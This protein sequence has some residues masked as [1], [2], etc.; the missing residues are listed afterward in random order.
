MSRIKKNKQTIVNIRRASCRKSLE[1]AALAWLDTID[2]NEGIILPLPIAHLK[3]YKPHSL[4]Q[5]YVKNKFK[6]FKTSSIRRTIN[7]VILGKPNNMYM[8]VLVDRYI[9]YD[10]K[11]LLMFKLKYNPHCLQTKDYIR[12][13]V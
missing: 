9:C 2:P 5:S 4:I 8:K 7:G 1:E 12:G 11:L 3:E 13:R 10:D 6:M